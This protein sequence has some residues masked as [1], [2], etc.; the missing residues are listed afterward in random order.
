VFGGIQCRVRR[1]HEC[2]FIVAALRVEANP[3]ADG[4][5]HFM[6]LDGVWTLC[7]CM[8]P[9]SRAFRSEAVLLSRRAASAGSVHP[10]RDAS[11]GVHN[12]WGPVLAHVVPARRPLVAVAT[13]MGLR[14]AG[15]ASEAQA[16]GARKHGGPLA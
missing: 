6:T 10:T 7:G 12:V 13:A 14:H 9:V 1:F 8:P 16:H 5:V 2:F 11:A 15:H 3:N 4:D